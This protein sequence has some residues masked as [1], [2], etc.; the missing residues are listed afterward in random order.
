MKCVYTSGLFLL[1]TLTHGR[2]PIII[3]QWSAPALP[4][5]PRPGVGCES[6]LDSCEYVTGKVKSPCFKLYRVHSTSFNKP[7]YSLSA[8]YPSLW[9]NVRLRLILFWYKTFSLSYGDYFLKMLFSPIY[10]NDIIYICIRKQQGL[11]QNKLNS[12]LVLI[13]TCYSK[14]GYRK[15]PKSLGTCIFQRP[16]LRGFY[17]EGLIYGGRFAFQNWLG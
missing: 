17:S 10:N 5:L 11:Y 2:Y 12:S 7:F 13:S 8:Q 9:V 15:I 4:D 6:Y 14:M 3:S 1:V 16:F